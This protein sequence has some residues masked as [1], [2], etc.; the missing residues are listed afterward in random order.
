LTADA[1]NRVTA[2]PTGIRRR[3]NSW[4]AFVWLPREKRKVRKTFPTL[5]AAKSWRADA[6]AL[7]AR[8]GLRAPKPTTVREAWEAWEEGAKTGTI[9]NRSGDRFKP[10]A[11]RGYAGAMRRHVLPELGAVRLTDLTRPD[12]QHFADKLLSAG[13][14]PSSIQVI[15]LPLR[16]IFRRAISRGE[17]AV[18]PCAGLELPAVR[19]R[20]ERYASP[21]EAEALIANVPERDRAIWATAMFAGLRLGEL[22][23][24]RVHDV[25]L[26]TGVIRVER[27]WDPAEGPIDRRPMPGGARCRSR[28]SCATTWPSTWREPAAAVPS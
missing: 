10:S 21:D 28:S 23:A 4:E 16:A 24:L 26:A 27:G 22:R 12:R 6:T 3:G 1:A 25:D 13:F 8:G 17:L 7:A 5:A 11:L 18:N 15:L 19:G 2:M 14:S 9:R 20:R